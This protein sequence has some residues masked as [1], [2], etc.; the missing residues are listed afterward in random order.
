M[1][2]CP[3][4][5]IITGLGPAGSFQPGIICFTVIDVAGEDRAISCSPVFIGNNSFDRTVFVY[6]FNLSQQR[7]LS[8]VVI[9]QTATPAQAA[10][11]PAVPQ[12][13]PQAISGA[14][15]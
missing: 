11:E 1:Y 14:F 12:Q 9:A 4:V 7:Q 15:L 6:D 3:G 8:P 13:S 5:V 10:P 2:L